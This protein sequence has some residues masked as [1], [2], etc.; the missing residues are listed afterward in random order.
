MLTPFDELHREEVR[1]LLDA[2]LVHR[3]DVGVRERDGRLR[4]LD[5]AADERWSNASSSRI[6]LTTS[7]FSKPPAPRSVARKTRAIPPR[8]SSARGRTCRRPAETMRRP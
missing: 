6:C 2:E 4:L 3:D 8:E 5:E 7:F 1:A